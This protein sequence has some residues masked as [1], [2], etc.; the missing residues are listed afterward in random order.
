MTFE[1]TLKK[2]RD[3][4]ENAYKRPIKKKSRWQRIV[5]VKL[6][7]DGNDKARNDMVVGGREEP[8]SSPML[9]GGV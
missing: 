7:G 8:A 5:G 3:I 1:K 4:S 2:V 6:G 9:R